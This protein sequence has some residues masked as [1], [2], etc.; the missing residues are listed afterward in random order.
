MRH[1]PIF[2]NLKN[3]TCLVVGAGGV[4]SRKIQSLIDSDVMRVNVIDTNAK[5]AEL[6]V[7]ANNDNVMFYSRTFDESDLDDTFLVI[8]CTSN[9]EI[10]LQIATL[11]HERNILCNIADQ[12]DQCSFLV[13]ATVRRGDLT[14][15]LS[16]SG[17]S[18]AF[19][20]RMR[21]ELQDVFG[22]EYAH[23]LTVMGRIRPL[24][25]ELG[26]ETQANTAVF[27]A[28]VNS[29]LLQTLKAQDIEACQQILKELLPQPLHTNISELLNGII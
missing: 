21:R 4:G 10:N 23:M 9:T 3:K 20:K 1:Y 5:S 22:D 17:L 14:L 24:M 25:L 8:A 13:P 15:A 26:L 11:C 2:L 7:I 28:L 29:D 27:R 12:P 19:T 16:S 18:P 6:D